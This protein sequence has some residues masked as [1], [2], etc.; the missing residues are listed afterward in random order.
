MASLW[1]A[2]MRSSQ[3]IA[4]IRIALPPTE[5][6]TGSSLSYGSGRGMRSLGLMKNYR[7]TKHKES[8][9]AMLKP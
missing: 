5:T 9:A 7:V 4:G 1:V 2:L 3:R 6:T 8:V